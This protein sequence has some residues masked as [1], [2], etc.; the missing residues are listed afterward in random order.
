MGTV[1][2]VMD[3]DAFTA[4]TDNI[5]VVDPDAR[6]LTWVPRDLWCAG[7]ENRVNKAFALGG[8][9]LLIAALAEHRLR[10]Q[11]SICLDRYAVERG[12]EGAVIPIQVPERMEFWYPLEP[13]MEIEEGRK[14]VVFESGLAHLSGERLHQWLGARYAVATAGS[15]LD[16]ID[17]QQ[18]LLAVMLGLGFDFRRFLASPESVRTSS[19][20]AIEEVSRVEAGWRFETIGPLVPARIDGK[21][22]L[23]NQR[24][25]ATDVGP[26]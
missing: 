21:E 25:R 19:E 20:A 10:V 7:I 5:V 11:N 26:R 9:R 2:S 8:H 23:L 3:R 6:T 15:D 13:T 1:V 24:R 18:R 17:R 12:L 4:N 16:R 14:R 22:V